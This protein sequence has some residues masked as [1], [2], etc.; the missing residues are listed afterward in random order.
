[1]ASSSD[2]LDDEF[3][4]IVKAE[5][6]R[7]IGFDLDAELSGQRTKALQYYRGEM[8]DIPSLDNRSR[9]VS[10][11]IADAVETLLPDLIEIFTSQD[12]ALEFIPQ[13]PHDVE[14]AKQET[15]YLRKVFFRD[16]PG[17]RI[18]H[19][20]LKDALLSKTGVVTWWWEDKDDYTEKFGPMPRAQAAVLLQQTQASYLQMQA[21]GIQPPNLLVEDLELSQDD[22][23]QQL[24]SWTI[25]APQEGCIKIAA[26]APEHFT[27]AADAD[28]LAGATYAAWRSYPRAQDLKAQGIDPDIVDELPQHGMPTDME[29]QA[30]NTVSE[31]MNGFGGDGATFDMRMVEIT[32]HFVRTNTDGELKLWKVVTGG[33][34]AVLISR[35]VVNQIEIAACTP[36][37]QPHRFYGESI[38]DRLLEIQRIKTALTR[39]VLDSGYFAVNQRPVVDMT[40]VNDFTL[41]DLL[42]NAPGHP[43]RVQG[44]G[45]VEPFS[46]AGL[47]FDGFAALEYFAVQSEQRT[48]VVRN[49]QGLAPDTLHD[50]ASGAAMLAAAAQKRIRLIARV[51][52]ETGLRDLYL[53]LH[54]KIR[55]SATQ[56]QV[57][58]L[59][60]AWVPID[61]TTWGERNQMVIQIGASRD[62]EIAMMMQQ[63]GLMKDVGETPY[64]P[65]IFTPENV[66]NMLSRVFK[67]LGDR[68][69][70]DVMTNPGN[71]PPQPPKPDPKVQADLQATQAQTQARVQAIQA[72]TAA[73]AQAAQQ[74]AQ[75]DAQI[76]QT[77]VQGQLALDQQR[78]AAQLDMDRQQAAQELALKQREMEMDFALKQHAQMGGLPQ[79]PTVGPAIGFGG[80]PG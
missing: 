73:Q 79:T 1:M 55:E 71:A 40:K 23:G 63:V 76:G 24:V 37:L 21:Q 65:M 42:T 10:T 77:K 43:I 44:A 46:N 61:P 9:A 16:N 3:L 50:T 48:G 13:G 56:Q 17:F 57:A 80:Q 78:Q 22:Y 47:G 15:D 7:S 69:V 4:N 72:Q 5:R 41:S 11:D 26:V 58:Q 45:A 28:T 52:A 27:I 18:L 64:G 74:R 19:D 66:F 35:E 25:R 6:A 59:R 31:T 30:R 62:V 60:G 20:F 39:M 2:G 33:D 32:T 49:A 38:A 70:D 34:E 12:D 14:A 53:G 68:N 36:Y 29:S 51:I 8:P 67:K 75:T 54:A